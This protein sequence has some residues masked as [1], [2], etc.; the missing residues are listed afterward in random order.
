[1]TLLFGIDKK[2]LNFTFLNFYAILIIVNIKRKNMNEEESRIQSNNNVESGIVSA[3]TEVAGSILKIAQ[4]RVIERVQLAAKE[5]TEN[6]VMLFA[7]VFAGMV[8]CIFML[9]GFAIWLGEITDL[10]L[11]FGLSITGGIIFIITLIVALTRKK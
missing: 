7:M 3:L 8:G 2:F 9:V 6:A 5:I 4:E 10:G 1:M 11:W